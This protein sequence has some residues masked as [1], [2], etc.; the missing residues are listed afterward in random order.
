MVEQ[1]KVVTAAGVSAGIDMALTLVHRIAG[2][3]AAQAIQLGIEYDPQPPFDTGSPEKA[4]AAIVDMVRQVERDEE[5]AAAGGLS[6]LLGTGAVLRR[7][8]RGVSL[9]ECRSRR[10]APPR[11]SC[12][13]AT[14]SR[15]TASTRCS[16]AAGWASSTRPRT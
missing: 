10:R 12:G 14:R 5:T 7:S 15:A 13:S 4:P 16:A 3:E 2:P 9:A 8:P 11:P 1:G 6:H